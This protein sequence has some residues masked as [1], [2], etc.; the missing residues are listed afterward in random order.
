MPSDDESIRSMDYTFLENSLW[1]EF[2]EDDSLNM[3][4]TLTPYTSDVVMSLFIIIPVK[5]ILFSV[6]LSVRLSVLV[7][8][9]SYF[10]RVTPHTVFITHKQNLCHL[11]AGCL[12]YVIRGSVFPYHPPPSKK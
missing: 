8:F 12:E 1:L 10:V 9:F 6:C 4:P 7:A 5:G 3:I 2:C 11:K